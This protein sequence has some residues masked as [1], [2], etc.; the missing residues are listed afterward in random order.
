M[1]TLSE[2]ED[3]IILKIRRYFKS[4]RLLFSNLILNELYDE[5]LV[6]CC[7]AKLGIVEIDH[8]DIHL[9]L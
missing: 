1:K 6:F 9:D 2:R 3:K 8:Y 5:I 4:I 7:P